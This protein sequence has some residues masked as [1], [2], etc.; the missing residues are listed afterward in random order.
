MAGPVLSCSH[1]HD[2]FTCGA[3]TK[4]SSVVLS[5]LGTGWGHHLYAHIPNPPPQAVERWD[6]LS[7]AEAFQGGLASPLPPGPT[8]LCFLVVVISQYL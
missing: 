8:P 2:W 7:L 1:S 4:V 5:R 6:Q 3:T